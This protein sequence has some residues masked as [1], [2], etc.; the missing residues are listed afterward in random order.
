MTK[1]KF[2]CYVS[3]CSLAVLGIYGCSK[4][5]KGFL[6]D[7]LYYLENPLVTSQGSITVSSPLVVDGSTAPM[8]VELTKI[9]DESGKEVSA[10]FSKT[11]SI[12]GFSGTVSYL[13]STLP[14]LNAKL[15]TTA[16]K[17]F[18]INPSGG[19]IQLTPATQYVPTGTYTISVK[20][21]NE[22][23]SK[24]LPD[25]C[26]III[27]GTGD[28]YVD[29]GGFYGG[30]FDIANGNYFAGVGIAPPVVVYTAS[31]TNKIIYK[32]IDQTGKLYNAQ[33]NGLTSRTNR[34]RM[35]DFD[36]YY[37]ELLTNNSIEY[38]FPLV[39]NQFPVF[40]NPGSAIGIV[41]RGNYG[42]A[43]AIPAAHNSTGLPVFVFLDMAFF[44]KGTY[45][46]TVNFTDISW[47]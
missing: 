8:T 42:I 34:W 35:K 1:N 31:A 46:I 30:T 47:K 6:S 2:L 10:I 45:T 33:A 43:P 44:T 18:S 11:D 13:D 40:T 21:S 38:Q 24:D 32:F 36:P 17:P 26:K 28:T 23:G 25:A 7:N 27:N 12:L 19:R 29:Y 9:V 37:P 41:P 4:V 14:L 15:A 20:A 3:A 39:P 5:E 16:A 22:R